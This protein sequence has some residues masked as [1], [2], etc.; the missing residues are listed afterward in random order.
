MD[1]KNDLQSA[2]KKLGQRKRRIEASLQ[3]ECTKRQKLELQVKELESS[4]KALKKT[5]QKQAVTIQKLRSGKSVSARGP[6]SKSWQSLSRQNRAVK[7]KQLAADIQSSLSFCDNSVFHP[8]SLQVENTHTG[9]SEVLDLKSGKFAAKTERCTLSGEEQ[10]HLSLYVKERFCISNEAFH[11]LSMIFQ[12]LPRSTSVSKLVKELNSQVTIS[13]TPNNT[14]GVQLSL[15]AQLSVTVERIF[16]TSP[17]ARLTSEKKL[18]I[19]LTGD[20]TNLGR[21]LH[22]VNIAFCVLDE[23]TAA[24]SPYGNHSLAIL[25]VSEKYE[26]LA[27]AL[28]DVCR[29]VA[30]LGSIE[31]NGETYVIEYFFGADWKFASAPLPIDGTWTWCG[32]PKTPQKG[33]EPL[34]KLKG[35]RS[36]RRV[37]RVGST[38]LTL[39]C[40]PQLELITLFLIL[41]TSSCVLLMFSLICSYSTS[42][43]QTESTRCLQ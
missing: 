27:D 7:K 43:G 36:F 33:Q 17:P 26:Q 3:A 22:V 25:R 39:H 10:L 6:S 14:I 40:F 28:E 5:T 31:I 11:E 32:Q 16:A 35:F 42:V 23:G 38:A 2:N 19:K 20:G 34:E 24:N 21:S 9:D 30:E 8:V 12:G 15:R 1:L 37:P 13:P 41:F 4:A 29:E 18:C